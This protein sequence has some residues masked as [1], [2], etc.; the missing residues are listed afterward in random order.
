MLVVALL[1]FVVDVGTAAVGSVV[2]V[3]PEFLPLIVVV[4]VV[5]VVVGTAGVGTAVVGT[6]VT[7]VPEFLLTAVVV[8]AAVV[9]NVLPV[10]VVAVVDVRGNANPA[11]PGKSVCAY[12]F[13]H[14]RRHS[15]RLMFE[16]ELSL[17]TAEICPRCCKRSALA[18]SFQAGRKNLSVE[19]LFFVLLH[20]N[21]PK[22]FLLACAPKRSSLKSLYKTSDAWGALPIT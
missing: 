19:V 17:A 16:L 14:R 21:T 10:V 5:A 8:G 2:I 1:A 18:V 3:V 7:V 13:V 15:S 20:C 22:R 11:V 6:A 4:A 9:G 12:S